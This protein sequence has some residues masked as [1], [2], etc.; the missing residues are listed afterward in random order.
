[1]IPVLNL[2]AGGCVVSVP[3]RPWLGAAGGVGVRAVVH[4][5]P[6]TGCIW[7]SGILVLWVHGRLTHSHCCRSWR[8]A[9]D[10]P[11]DQ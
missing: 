4:R 2:E 3:R 6:V 9:H 11:D 7:I 10:E 5:D 8:F 1:M